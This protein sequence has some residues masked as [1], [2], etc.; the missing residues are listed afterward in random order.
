MR[1]ASS[2]SPNATVFRS[3]VPLTDEQIRQIAPSIFAEGK[4]DSRSERY[5]YVPTSTILAKLREEGFSP[6]MVAQT[7]VRDDGKREFA[8]HMLRLRYAGQI[9]AAEANEIIL[10]NS[11]DGSSSY[12]LMSGC[13][14]F[15]CSNGLVRGDTRSD[16]RVPHKGKIVDDIIEGAFR[17]VEDFELVNQERDGMKALT[18]SQG[19][20]EAFAHSALMLKY[21]D[22]TPPVTELQ[23]LRANR[24]EDKKSDMWTTMNRVQENLTRGGL[25]GR[26]A[27]GN[28]VKT[29]EVKGITQNIHLN[30]A[31]WTLAQSMAKLKA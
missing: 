18:L 3:E 11:H 24:H 20:Q 4:H 2:F 6:F 9:N 14:R 30:R 28:R 31:I 26:N 27:N 1:L 22:A 16:I 13:F 29:R 7:R 5:T 8:K 19:E 17:V 12:Q 25:H 15:V 23:V 10:L 21:E